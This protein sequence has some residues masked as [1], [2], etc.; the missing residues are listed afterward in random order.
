MRYCYCPKCGE[1]L[2]EKEIGD[3][4]L[5]PFCESCSVP[6]WDAFNTC[7]ITAV[8]N[9]KNEVALLKQNYINITYYVCVAGHIKVGES[10]EESVI[11]EVNFR[12]L[13]VQAHVGTRLITDG[14][15]VDNKF[16]PLQDSQIVQLLDSLVD[17]CT[18]HSTRASYLQ[19]RYAGI[20]CNQLQ[21]CFVQ[22]I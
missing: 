5:V 6:W 10:A 21:D 4:G 16:R 9:E 18:R 2:I 8:T 11:R 15:R 19:K 14:F 13:Q 22:T 12:M 1:K 20:V 3:E 7:I 17:G